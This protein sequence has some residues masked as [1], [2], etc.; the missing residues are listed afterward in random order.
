[1]MNSPKKTHDACE[2]CAD[3]CKYYFQIY[4][5]RIA[6]RLLEPYLEARA[7]DK[8][9]TEDGRY[10]IY[11]FD[12]PCPHITEDDLCDIYDERPEFCAKWP[13]TTQPAWWP[14]CKLMR[15]RFP[16]DKA[17]GFRALKIN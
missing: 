7:I 9:K 8:F 17:T 6:D 4:S 16:V 15:E 14:R 11:V 2:G 10:I 5:V 3:C 1:M 13:V 12:Q